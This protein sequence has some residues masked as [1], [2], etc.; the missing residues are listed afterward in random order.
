[1][2]DSASGTLGDLLPPIYGARMPSFFDQPAINE[3]RATCSDCAMCDKTNAPASL[4]TTAFRPDV[5]CCSYHPTLPNYLAGAI[6]EDETM[7]EGRA[8]VRAKIGARIGVTPQWLAAPRKYLVLLDAARESSFGRSQSLLCPYYERT[9]GNCTIWKHR[10]GVC[11]TFFC[12]HTGGAPAHKFWTSLRRYLLHVERA[13]A[14]HVARSIDP[15][16]V[17]PT[18]PRNRLTPEDLEDRPPND[19]TYAAYW[20]AWL[21]REE[22]F[23]VECARRVRA[24]GRDELGRVVGDAG[25]EILAEVR[26]RYEDTT[27]PKLA[28]RLLLNPDMLVTR[29][30]GGVGVTT[31]S[32]YDSLFLTD[33]LHEALGHFT[34]QSPVETV[35]E[36]LRTEHDVDLPTDLLLYLQQ[37]DVVREPPHE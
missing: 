25:R 37:F 34:G 3:T 6:L 1:M 12:K 11:T 23:Y 22:A 4:E 5:K 36:K 16:L 19:A 15:E 9:E 7:A 31:Y 13:L 10:E 27:K 28:P 33:A 26:S 17:E 24:L 21:G 29:G 2:S 30:E 18:I 14:I 32:R 20:G 35:L 8:R